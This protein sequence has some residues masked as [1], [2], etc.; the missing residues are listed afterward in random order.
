MAICLDFDG[1]I[2]KA[3]SPWRGRTIISDPP[4]EKAREA[5]EQLMKYHRILVHSGRCATEEGREA[6]EAW[7]ERQ[8][9]IV[10]AV[11]KDKPLAR[12]FVDDRAIQFKGDWA[13]T[14]DDIWNFRQWQRSK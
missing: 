2:H 14:L 8:G 10:D 6:I 12:I 11:V 5:I 1:V 3:L 13:Q 4:V 7:L 9:I